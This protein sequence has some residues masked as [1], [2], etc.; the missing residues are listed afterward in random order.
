MFKLIMNIK[1]MLNKPI[2]IKIIN[3]V[4]NVIFSL[5]QMIQFLFIP[6]I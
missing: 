3:Y 6:A 5:L 1:E 4:I 2:I